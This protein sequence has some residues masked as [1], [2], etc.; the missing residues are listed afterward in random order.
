MSWRP[1]FMPM[2]IEGLTIPRYRVSNYDVDQ[3]VAEY[4]WHG[5]WKAVDDRILGKKAIYMTEHE[6]HNAIRCDIL[7]NVRSQLNIRKR[8]RKIET[9]PKPTQ[10][11]YTTIEKW[12]RES[13]AKWESENA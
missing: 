5:D 7:Y 2:K 11:S 3:F 10:V 1:Y 12:V 9:R 8:S 6:A 13:I 4:R